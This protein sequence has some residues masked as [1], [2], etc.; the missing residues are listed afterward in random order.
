MATESP[1]HPAPDEI[2]DNERTGSEPNPSGKSG[3]SKET[4]ARAAPLSVTEAG[5]P[6]DSTGS[7]TAHQLSWAP[8][9]PGAVG[10]S[11]RR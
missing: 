4:E 9:A 6:S 5:R 10:C 11:C 1:S 3:G 8:E 2:P 7:P